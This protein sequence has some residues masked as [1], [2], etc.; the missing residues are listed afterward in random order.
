MAEKDAGLEEQFNFYLANQEELVKQYGGRYIVIKDRKVIGA[1]DSEAEAIKET[2][3]D[4]ELGTFIV[5]KCEAGDDAY[6]EVFHSR[7]AFG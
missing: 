6:T 3:R 4:H 2:S 5:Q 7:V 1:Y